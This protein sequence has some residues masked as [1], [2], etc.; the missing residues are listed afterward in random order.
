MTLTA[1]PIT[2][3]GRRW[4]C[5]PLGTEDSDTDELADRVQHL[6]ADRTIFVGFVYFLRPVNGFGLVGE[7]RYFTSGVSASPCA[8]EWPIHKLNGVFGHTRS[9]PCFPLS[10]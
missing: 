4:P 2:S 3:A 10:M 6:P 8:G 9:V 5:G 1:L 7:L